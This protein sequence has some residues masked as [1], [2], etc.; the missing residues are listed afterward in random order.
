MPMT[1]KS[2]CQRMYSTRLAK[3]AIVLLMVY[4]VKCSEGNSSAPSTLLL[5]RHH[6]ASNKS[7]N[8]KKMPGKYAPETSNAKETRSPTTYTYTFTPSDFLESEPTAHHSTAPINAPNQWSA[9]PTN[10]FNTANPSALPSVAAS[11]AF[12]PSSDPDSRK[13]S[14]NPSTERTAVP[15]SNP[16]KQ[17]TFMLTSSPPSV[18]ETRRPSLRLSSIPSEKQ[19]ES[20]SFYPTNLIDEIPSSDPQEKSSEKPSLAPNPNPSNFPTNQPSENPTFGP[21]KRPSIGPSTTPSL[22]PSPLPSK[23]PSILPS[24]RR[25][26]SPSSQPPTEYPTIRPSF[27]LSSH[28]SE[29]SSDAP[30]STAFALTPYT[31]GPSRKPFSMYSQNPASK[32]TPQS[33]PPTKNSDRPSLLSLSETPSILPSYRRIPTFSPS[34]IMT[35]LETSIIIFS[36]TPSQV[37]FDDDSISSASPSTYSTTPINASHSSI[38]PTAILTNIS[39]SPSP[40]HAGSSGTPTA[41]PTF[42]S[43]IISNENPSYVPSI[44]KSE[45][46]TNDP[47]S[48]LA[49][50]S[51]IPSESSPTLDR[52][53]ATPNTKLTNMPSIVDYEN[54]PTYHPTVM[55]SMMPTPEPPTC[56]HQP[57]DRSKVSQQGSIPS[58]VPTHSVTQAYPSFLPSKIL[59][60]QPTKSP[61]GQ[62]FLSMGP[63]RDSHSPTNYP[64]SSAPTDHPSTVHSESPSSSILSPVVSTPSEQISLNS[65]PP[66]G[67]IIIRGTAFTVTIRAQIQLSDDSLRAIAFVMHEDF[68]AACASSFKSSLGVIYSTEIVLVREHARRLNDFEKILEVPL[69]LV[70]TAVITYSGTEETPTVLNHESLDATVRSFYSS[71]IHMDKI[72]MDL[73]M[74]DSKELTGVR[75]IKFTAFVHNDDLD[76]PLSTEKLIESK[77]ENNQALLAGTIICG[78]LFI[79]VVGSALLFWHGRKNKADTSEGEGTFASK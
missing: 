3:V 47:I 61:Q 49:P 67:N 23:S 74:T 77:E 43:T 56:T 22:S 19:S 69:T 32:T 26:S 6:K 40:S 79:M 58:F 55:R 12:Q 59:S 71:S 38:I 25:T 4:T 10:E 27:T 46:P 34:T 36:T 9:E 51:N 21:R 45:K 18:L 24:K 44:I 66:S 50:L 7:K 76:K 70:V 57:T 72:V 8:K 14:Q 29:A 42:K 54:V 17:P 20:P 48:I 68:E 53:N 1:E 37:P 52:P 5:T 62:G 35:T 75:H 63:A 11:S 16:T 2:S 13:P 39:P 31:Y 33:R 78:G 30:T 64:H 60:L 65:A 15:S 41:F 28:L 73:K